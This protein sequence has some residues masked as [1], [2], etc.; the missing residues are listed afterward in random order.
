MVKKA[1]QKKIAT[2]LITQMSVKNGKKFRRQLTMKWSQELDHA[3]TL[4][5]TAI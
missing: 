4:H 5:S 2:Y 3:D 1:Q